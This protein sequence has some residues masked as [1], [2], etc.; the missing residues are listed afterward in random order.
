MCR[1]VSMIVMS[2]FSVRW[3]KVTGSHSEI[4]REHHLCDTGL[5][6]QARGEAPFVG[7]E[8]VPPEE[9]YDTPGSEWVFSVD[10]GYAPIL[11]AW[12]DA[13][14]AEEA[15][16]AVLPQWIAECVV[17]PGQIRDTVLDG[18]RVYISGGTIGHV[19]GGTVQ[20]VS[21]GTVQSVSG[22]T[23]RRVSGGTICRVYGGTIQYVHGGTIQRVYNGTICRV[24]GG[25][26]QYVHGGTIQRV[27]GGAI[28]R[29]CGDGTVVLYE[30]MP[31]IHIEERG[32]ILDRTGEAV[33]VRTASDH[34]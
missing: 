22:G 28:Q 18:Q 33:R 19:R 24:Y 12:W 5:V 1:D 8:I 16:R 30:P 31:D 2:D 4:I 6:N 21:G 17:F 26:I 32:A 29:V 3:S 27:D 34:N 10:S 25:T 14:R 7:I 20:S 15:V 9:R 13:A 23:I 11:P